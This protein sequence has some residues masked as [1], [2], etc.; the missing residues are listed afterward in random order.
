MPAKLLIK[1][2]DAPVPESPGRWKAGRIISVVEIGANLAHG[3]TPSGGTFVHF[4]V[5]N[6]TVAEMEQYFAYYNRAIDMA[7]IQGPDINGFRRINVRNNNCNVSGTIGAWTADE[8]NEIIA[9]W[10]AKYPTCNLVTVG[11]PNPNTWTCEGTFTTGQAVEFKSTVVVVGE[12]V[13]DSRRIW[14]ITPA[15][16]ANIISAGG[17]QSGTSIQL[18]TILRDARLD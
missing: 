18:N 2:A 10:N 17:S 12:G 1:K 6:R 14:Y 11:F 4:I 13:M 8:A 15:G 16:I 7:V 9:A 5:T 3:D